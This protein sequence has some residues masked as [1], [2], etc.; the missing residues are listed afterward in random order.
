MYGVRWWCPLCDLAFIPPLE[1][2][3]RLPVGRLPVDRLPVGAVEPLAGVCGSAAAK[4]EPSGAVWL[5]PYVGD[6]GLLLAAWV[7]EVALLDMDFAVEAAAAFFAASWAD[8][9]AEVFAADRATV[10]LAGFLEL[11]GV[12]FAVVARVLVALTGRLAVAARA[13][14]LDAEVLA[15]LD[16]ARAAVALA[17]LLLVAVLAFGA[18]CDRD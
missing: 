8:V 15:L 18:A 4:W 7:F 11:L 6:D 13:E 9:C 5:A 10:A 17:G 16:M 1:F 12:A 3:C 14:L 2:A